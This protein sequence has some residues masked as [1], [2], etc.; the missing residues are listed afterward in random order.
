MIG[1]N[2]DCLCGVVL[3]LNCISTSLM[4]GVNYLK[5]AFLAASMICRK[6]GDDIYGFTH[7]CSPPFR[8]IVATRDPRAHSMRRV[9]T[10]V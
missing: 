3:E 1:A 4:G 9:L 7:E 2:R 5:R 8:L 6:F 10:Q